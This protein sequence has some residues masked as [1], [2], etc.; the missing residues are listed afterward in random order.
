[1]ATRKKSETETTTTETTEETDPLENFPK[2]VK[3]GHWEH[4]KESGDTRWIA[5]D[6]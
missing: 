4:D 2:D 6:A 5:D 1:M 3:G